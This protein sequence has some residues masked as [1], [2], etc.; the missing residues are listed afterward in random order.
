[1]KKKRIASLIYILPFLSL[2]FA[3]PIYSLINEDTN[4]SFSENRVLQQLPTKADLKDWSFTTKYESYIND[5]LPK[6]DMLIKSYTQYEMF[7]GK[8][9]IR[10]LYISDSEQLILVPSNLDDQA[11]QEAAAKTNS[12]KEKANTLGKEVFFAITPRKSTI[13]NEMLIEI[14]HKNEEEK[15]NLF[16]SSLSIPKENI[17]D[18][19]DFFRTE[20]SLEERD[21]F[22]F[23][24]DFHWNAQGAIT[25]FSAVYKQMNN[26]LHM[27]TKNF[28]AQLFNL[29]KVPKAEF[30]GD[31]NRRLQNQFQVPETVAYYDLPNE[32]DLSVLLLEKD[33]LKKVDV[34]TIYAS[35]VDQPQVSY[36]DLFTNNL[37][38][39][40]INHSK[41]LTHKKILIFKDSYQN[42][43]L[44]FFVKYFEQVEVVDQRYLGQRDCYEVLE[45]SNADIVLIMY[46]D[47]NLLG[48]MFDFDK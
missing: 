20:F 15:I 19:V 2:I 16:K 29:T 36:N 8:H 26:A 42:A 25:A 3:V 5:Q 47:G 14:F 1:M 40:K 22:Y 48:S 28:D 31:L 44:P 33:A 30:E 9:Y 11:I 32:K 21:N 43:T 41:A 6:R 34:S 17:I 39:Y 38:Y 7:V 18:I 45:A 10:N 35:H 4:R 24:S 46:N 23:K 27:S 37:G 13:L 12:L